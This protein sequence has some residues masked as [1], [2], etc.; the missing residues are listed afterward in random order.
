VIRP[1]PAPVARVLRSGVFCYPASR[2]PSG[3]H[4]TPVVFA[5]HASRLWVTTSRGSVKAR[6]WR[7]DPRV[8]GFVPAGDRGVVFTGRVVTF[9]LLDPGSWPRSMLHAP[10]LTR[11]ATAFTTKNARFFAG[12]AVDAYRVP[13]AWTPPGRVFA[14]VEME[15]IA[16]L[17]DDDVARTWGRF[18]RSLTSATTFARSRSRR[19]PISGVPATVRSRIGTSGVAVLG[20]DAPR[21]PPAALP[22]AWA[23]GRGELYAILPTRVLALAN[24][25]SDAR[26]SLTIDRAS[27]WRAR[28]MTG[29]LVQG[30]GRIHEIAKLESGAR[31]A[32]RLAAE[33]GLDPTTSSVVNVRPRR[34][35]WWSGWDSASVRI[36]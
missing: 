4:V 33:A 22:C 26:V 15:R 30:E 35:V 10:S 29:V 16:L 2:H 6:T 12:Y 27:Q 18:G 1:F 28:A 19:D 11:A 14:G 3:P 21:R 36:T 31:A 9:D 5:T 32:E 8:G 34:I 13:L 25:G 20:L 24:P 23:L 17:K 7:R